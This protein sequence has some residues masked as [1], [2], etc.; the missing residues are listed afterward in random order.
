MGF[1]LREPTPGMA[2]AEDPHDRPSAGP[3]RRIRRGSLASRKPH[4]GPISNR[5]LSSKYR[6][7]SG[8]C[9]YGYR[10][11][12]PGVGRWTRRDPLGETADDAPYAHVGNSHSA[13]D[14]FGL[15]ALDPYA[16]DP[17]EETMEL[18]VTYHLLE[19]AI[20][21]DALSREFPDWHSECAVL[22]GPG[23]EPIAWEYHLTSLKYEKAEVRRRPWGDYIAVVRRSGPLP[24]LHYETLSTVRMDFPVSHMKYEG[25]Y[26]WCCRCPLLDRLGFPGYFLGPY[27]KAYGYESP[28]IPVLQDDWNA[29]VAELASQLAARVTALTAMW[30]SHPDYGGIDLGYD[31][32]HLRLTLADGAIPIVEHR[33]SRSAGPNFY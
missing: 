14:P 32:Q 8:L 13:V 6:D 21:P 2:T 1:Y 9:Y 10:Y 3:S 16:L 28:H 20:S 33:T 25:Y 29:I 15:H 30:A 31:L 24:R 7:E 23:W 19:R 12:A 27:L 4:R 26:Q 11:Y 5:I 22:V 18:A 17:A